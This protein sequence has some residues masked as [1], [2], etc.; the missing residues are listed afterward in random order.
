MNKYNN[1]KNKIE[2]NKDKKKNLYSEKE[3]LQKN[4]FKLQEFKFDN[5]I[6][7]KL[8]ELNNTLK[9]LELTGIE[10][11]NKKTNIENKIKTNNDLI[12][13]INERNRLKKCIIDENN[14][15]GFNSSI[16]A[17]NNELK[18]FSNIYN[19]I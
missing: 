12:K 14:M 15:E 3:K 4:I 9:S 18:S 13:T 11:K 7:A 2:V 17:L 1:L 8:T 6:N 16:N 5:E 19:D 10:I